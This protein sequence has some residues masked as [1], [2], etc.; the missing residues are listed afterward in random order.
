MSS[1]SAQEYRVAGV[2]KPSNSIFGVE[3]TVFFPVSALQSPNFNL[4]NRLGMQ[5]M[6][7]QGNPVR[8]LLTSRFGLVGFNRSYEA[9]FFLEP[10]FYLFHSPCQAHLSNFYIIPL[11]D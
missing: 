9:F 10:L 8:F 6:S 5:I 7:S 1:V 11:L 4:T 3:I 2:G